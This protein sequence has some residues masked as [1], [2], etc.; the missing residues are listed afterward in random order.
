[1]YEVGAEFKNEGFSRYVTV[2]FSDPEHRAIF[3]VGAHGTVEYSWANIY[4]AQSASRPAEVAVQAAPSCAEGNSAQNLIIPR[5][6]LEE[7]EKQGFYITYPQ[8]P[9]VPKRLSVT[10]GFMYRFQNHAQR[11]SFRIHVG[12]CADEGLWFTI[13]YIDETTGGALVAEHIHD[14]IEGD[15]PRPSLEKT[16][17]PAG[18]C[19]WTHVRAWDTNPPVQQETD[20]KYPDPDGDTTQLAHSKLRW[21]HYRTFEGRGRFVNLRVVDSGA[22]EVTSKASV[23]GDRLWV[24]GIEIDPNVPWGE[25]EDN[26]IPPPRKTTLS[27]RQARRR[28]ATTW[29]GFLKFKHGS[30]NT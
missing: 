16:G 12:V 20:G 7:L 15:S 24:L 13:E 14:V 29:L 28:H 6:N 26:R 1:M 18:G 3:E 25:G 19:K 5:W 10:E 9:L 17:P 22:D 21:A 23:R 30:G 8:N 4:I 27:P 11:E 2:D